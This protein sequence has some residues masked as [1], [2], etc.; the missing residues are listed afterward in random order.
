[1]PCS[2]YRSARRAALACVTA[3]LFSA[4]Q[5]TPSI[6]A[7]SR[8]S[9]PPCKKIN[10][11]VWANHTLPQIMEEFQVDEQ[12]VMKCTQKKGKRR[13]E[14]ATKAPPSKHATAPAAH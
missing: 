2:R 13:K 4:A 1:M 12:Q 10:E 8:K 3:L 5:P 14:K 6:H 7:A 11:A 9:K